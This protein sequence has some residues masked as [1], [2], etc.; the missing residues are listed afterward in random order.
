MPATTT[1]L[2]K[3]R[4]DKY[5]W[6]IRIFKT[7]SLATEACSSGKVCSRS[8]SLKP[9]YSVKPGDIFHIYLSKEDTRIIEVVELL[10]KR[11][12]VEKVKHSFIDH[13]PPREKDEVLP[14][15]FYSPATK[16]RQQQGRPTKKENRQMRKFLE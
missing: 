6:A 15:V 11:Q 12:S 2:L 4:I 7:R 5:L 8:N 9:S 16:K 13:T 1:N 3:L 10:G 14:S